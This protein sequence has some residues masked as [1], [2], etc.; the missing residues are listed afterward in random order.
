MSYLTHAQSKKAL[1]HIIENVLRCPNDTDPIPA[2][3]LYCNVL[4]ILDLISFMRDQIEKELLYPPNPKEPDH[5]IPLKLG[6]K[7]LLITLISFIHF[8]CFTT[9][10]DFM[11]I[12]MQAYDT[13]HIGPDYNRHNPFGDSTIVTSKSSE[14]TKV[15]RF[16]SCIK[17]DLT[18]YS[19]LSDQK[20]WY[21]YNHCLCMIA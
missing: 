8:N 18:C 3:I 10:E 7:G 4:G 11:G 13:Y 2:S 15:E 17:F 12:T 5:I 21:D 6:D 14:N 1:E 19:E 16:K 9:F 20:F